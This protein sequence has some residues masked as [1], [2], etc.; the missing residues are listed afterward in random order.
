MLVDYVS[1]VW[2]IVDNQTVTDRMDR[3]NTVNAQ[4]FRMRF[5]DLLRIR[6]NR[7]WQCRSIV[8]KS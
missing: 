1:K 4:Y 3:T 7:W 2:A 8:S 5:P 6:G